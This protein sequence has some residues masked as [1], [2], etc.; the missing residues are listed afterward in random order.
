MR[1]IIKHNDDFNERANTLLSKN[2]SLTLYSRKGWCWLCVRG[3]LETE[4]DCYILTQSSSDHSST[5]SSSWLGLLNRG[6]LRAASLFSR[7][8]LVPQLSPT[9]TGTVAP[10]YIIVSRTPVSAISLLI[11]TGAS[12]DWRLGRGSIFN[13]FLVILVF[14]C[15]WNSYFVCICRPLNKG[16]MW[17]SQIFNRSLTFISVF[18]FSTSCLTKVLKNLVC[19]TIFSLLQENTW[20]HTF[21]S[22]IS[23]MGNAKKCHRA[24]EIVSLCPYSTTINIHFVRICK[25]PKT[26]H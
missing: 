16:K 7:W 4:T 15:E 5:S 22:G 13:T 23:A 2:I 11:Y 14:L 12:L 26:L 17:H 25:L 3:E 1:N 20:I 9:P 10:C 6:S 24:F 19:S 21:P 8:H 18:S